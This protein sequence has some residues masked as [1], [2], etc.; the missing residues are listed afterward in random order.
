MNRAAPLLGLAVA[1]WRLVHVSGPVSVSGTAVV[2][3]DAGLAA[4]RLD[5]FLDAQT[6]DGAIRTGRTAVAFIGV[7]DL[8]RGAVGEMARPAVTVFIERDGQLVGG[9]KL[10]GNV[11]L[12]GTAN[13]GAVSVSGSGILSAD[14]LVRDR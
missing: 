5:G 4:V 12:S 10:E 2:P 14:V 13:P 8:T 7:V 1:T 11:A 9:A 6:A 3:R